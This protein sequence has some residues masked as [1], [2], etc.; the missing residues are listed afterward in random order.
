MPDEKKKKE[1]RSADLC[2]AGATC[3]TMPDGFPDGLVIVDTKTHRITRYYE[4][5]GKEGKK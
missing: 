3:G 4:Y 2:I 5:V 1:Y